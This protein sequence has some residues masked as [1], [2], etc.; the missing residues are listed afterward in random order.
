MSYTYQGASGI[1]YKFDLYQWADSRARIWQSGVVIHA[2][3]ASDPLFICEGD[4]IHL[5]VKGTQTWVVAPNQRESVLVY[6]CVFA[7]EKKRRDACEDLI[8]Y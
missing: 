7:D 1:A 5:I 2:I 8:L 6:V 4:N 3:F